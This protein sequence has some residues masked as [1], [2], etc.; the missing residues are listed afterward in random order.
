VNKFVAQNANNVRSSHGPMTVE[1]LVKML[2]EDVA[3]AMWDGGDTWQGCHIALVLREHG[4][5]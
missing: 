2:L 3:V 1:L 5:L 4:V